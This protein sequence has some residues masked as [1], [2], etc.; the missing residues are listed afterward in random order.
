MK[1]VLLLFGIFLIALVSCQNPA[2][3]SDDLATVKLLSANL[4]DEISFSPQQSVTGSTRTVVDALSDGEDLDIADLAPQL[5]FL[6][7]GLLP[8]ASLLWCKS[9]ILSWVSM[10]VDRVV[11]VG[12]TIPSA[13]L[14]A[15]GAT[16]TM[17][18]AKYAFDG[19]TLSI[20]TN[21]TFSGPW[22]L[23]MKMKVTV[24]TKGYRAIVSIVQSEDFGP[25]DYWY[26]VFD[27]DFISREL[28]FF[29]IVDTT[30]LSDYMISKLSPNSD[31]R[32]DLA[33]DIKDPSTSPNNM[34]FYLLNRN[35]GVYI[36]DYV[37][38][39]A[40]DIALYD[41]DYSFIGKTDFT[42]NVSD[43]YTKDTYTGFWPD[44]YS[45]FKT[46]IRSELAAYY[47]AEGAAADSGTLLLL[48]EFAGM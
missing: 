37:E 21:M 5:E 8:S 38:D 11:E 26:W 28:V 29:E 40:V 22:T 18:S 35:D 41:S 48:S 12:E 16:M 23:S 44:D 3:T 20:W 6:N 46:G 4:P 15:M 39:S 1:P 30:V 13:A 47:D 25:D 17:N 14:D 2:G 34:S 10:D 7:Y 31:G 19:A 45:D 36:S 27:F 33:I 32:Y 43:Q 42:L 9:E 24:N